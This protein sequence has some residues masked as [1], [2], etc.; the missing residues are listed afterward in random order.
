MNEQQQT[1]R[2]QLKSSRQDVQQNN[3]QFQYTGSETYLQFLNSCGMNLEETAIVNDDQENGVVEVSYLEL[4]EMNRELYITAFFDRMG[5]TF[6]VQVPVALTPM[7]RG[8][9]LN[10]VNSLNSDFVR[11]TVY[12]LEG[13]EPKLVARI[14][15]ETF[16]INWL[17]SDFKEIHDFSEEHLFVKL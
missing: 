6:F 9:V 5:W 17:L 12:L 2:S 16:D 7:N 11:P 15:R 4:D 8:N 10:Y 13:E 3:G 1:G 14:N